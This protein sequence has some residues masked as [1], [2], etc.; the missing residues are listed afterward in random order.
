M[1]TLQYVFS[2]AP[3]AEGRQTEPHTH[4]REQKETHELK[5]MGIL[6][7]HARDEWDI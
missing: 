1:T 2:G 3:A 6:S 4:I 5:H 7:A